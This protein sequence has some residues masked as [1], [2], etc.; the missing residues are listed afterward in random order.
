MNKFVKLALLMIFTFGFVA[1]GC[2]GF[3]K[4]SN[5]GISSN[6]TFPEHIVTY[7][8]QGDVDYLPISREEIKDGTINGTNIIRWVNV[9]N[10]TVWVEIYK[11]S[12]G[13]GL[14]FSQEFDENG[15]PVIYDGD[16]EELKRIYGN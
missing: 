7:Q 8:V 11:Y 14:S 13:Y 6:A 16:V 15:K 9:N 12:Q 2:S 10:K 4:V 3:T 5:S 1:V